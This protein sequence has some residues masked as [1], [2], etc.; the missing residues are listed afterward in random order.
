[1][2]YSAYLLLFSII[3]GISAPATSYA[4]SCMD[5]ASSIENHATNAQYT[6][7]TATAGEVTEYVQNKATDE[8][9]FMNDG[10]YTGQYIS[11]SE[12]H[13]GGMDSQAYVYFQKNMSWGYMC[14][15]QPPKAGVAS[16]YVLAKDNSPFGLTRVVQVYS[17]DSLYANDLL[18]AL[19][20]DGATG[21][22]FERT[23]ASWQ[24]GLAATL[25][26][27]VFFIRLKLNEWRMWKAL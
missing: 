4:L 14:T 6:I 5:P 11:V 25:R 10:G 21:E 15:N 1:M 8:Q 23:A 20:L 17:L 2:K 22:V 19:E 24:A 12:S 7:V 26:E 18:A 13:K 9:P 16:I 3:G 27:M